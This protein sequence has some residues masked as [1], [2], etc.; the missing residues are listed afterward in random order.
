MAEMT[1]NPQKRYRFMFKFWLDI[2]KDDEADL[3]AYVAYLKQERSFARTV[4]QGLALI[5][6]LRQGK[7]DLLFQLFPDLKEQLQQ[8]APAPELM[9]PVD[10]IRDH[11]QRLE[12]LLIS[13]R[14]EKTALAHPEPLQLPPETKG[15][16]GR[17]SQT[18]D[19]LNFEITV[20]RSKENP[21]YNIMLSMAK[22]NGTLLDL[23]RVVL[24]YGLENG[25]IPEPARQALK[26]KLAKAPKT[27]EVPPPKKGQ[28]GPK[29]LNAPPI[30]A[31][32]LDDVQLDFGLD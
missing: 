3:V 12:A 8:P 13:G 11:L 6:E 27:E 5:K 25:K 29:R 1:Q 16:T 22:L 4:R 18:D 7:T 26:D 28:L 20:A 9:P 19:S 14:P 10:D 23:P 24:E 15:K 30:Q 31:P 17:S 2:K 32:N 21:A